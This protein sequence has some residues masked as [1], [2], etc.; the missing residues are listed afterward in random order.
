M[1]NDVEMQV[2]RENHAHIQEECGKWKTQA[3]A[4]EKNKL[5][6]LREREEHG[7]KLEDRDRKIRELKELNHR[8][9]TKLEEAEQKAQQT[10]KTQMETLSQERAKATAAEVHLKT[11]YDM[12]VQLYYHLHSCN[13]HED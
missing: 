4:L 3:T 10:I 12:E 7:S 1:S 6:L 9:K 8:L 11:Q 2:L 5:L 13:K